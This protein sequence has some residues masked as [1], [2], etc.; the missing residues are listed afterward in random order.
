MIADIILKSNNIFDGVGNMPFPGAVAVKD[1][2]II[3]TGQYDD[4]APYIGADTVIRDFGD[5]LIMPGFI[6]NHTHLIMM[7]M[8]MSGRQVDLLGASSENECIERILKFRKEHPDVERIYAYGWSA[9]QWG[10]SAATPSRHSL[11]KAV[12]DIPVCMQHFF[13]HAIWLNT[14]AIEEA[15]ISSD[16]TFCSG[17]SYAETDSSGN[18]TGMV[19]ETEAMTGV[20]SNFQTLPEDIMRDAIHKVLDIMAANGITSCADMATGTYP[21]GDLPLYRSLHR[22]DNELPSGLPLRVH[23]YP[24]LGFDCDFEAAE[25]ARSKF[26]AG[27][28]RFS[29]LKQFIDGIPCI[30]SAYLLSPYIDVPDTTGLPVYPPDIYNKVIPEA[31]RR[32]FDVRVH[33]IGDGAVR[34]AI[35]A[36]EL[37]HRAGADW[38]AKNIIEHIDLIAP[39]DIS[40]M[41]DACVTASVQPLHLQFQAPFSEPCYGKKRLEEESYLYRSMLDAG[42]PLV[43]G[44]DHP[45]IDPFRNIHAAITRSSQEGNPLSY[46]DEQKM[47]LTEALKAYTSKGA[48]AI[49]RDSDLGMLKAGYL[50]DI[51]VID[52]PVFTESPEKISRRKPVMTISGGNIVY[53][54]K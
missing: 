33:A 20:L 15:G 23:F 22:L 27:N 4:A 13:S 1:T 48:A 6:D 43:M 29:G 25:K 38:N 36:Y 34:L 53:E 3:Y 18:L 37:S 26:V 45:D 8:G 32:G 52:G 39:E 28:V 35:D 19:Y 49:N 51:V 9:D 44:T 42:I 21:A 17:M 47:T 24:S 30:H 40:R 12:G 16:T 46:N 5:D 2:H 7:V 11:D 14:K 41:S 10:D 50:A 54:K 31:N